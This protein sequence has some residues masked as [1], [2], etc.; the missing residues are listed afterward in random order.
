[1]IYIDPPYNTGND[2]I[3]PDDYSE[4]L[5]TYL[6]YTGQ[7]D[8]D[9]RKFGTNTDAAGRFDSKWLNMMFPRLYLARN[10]LTDDGFLFVSIDDGEVENLKRLCDEVFG[11][12]R[13]VGRF[14]VQTNPKGRVLDRHISRTH[15]Y[16]LVYEKEAASREL[17]IAKSED[18]VSRDYALADDDGRHYRLLEL[19]NTHRQFGRETRP[20]L[21]YPLYVDRTNDKVLVAPSATAEEVWPTWDDGFEG[22][23]TWGRDKA[24]A[25]QGLLKWREVNGRLKIY[26]K[27]YSHDDDGVIVRKKL[28]SILLDRAFAT[29]RGQEALDSIMGERL[30]Q[31]PKP[32][33]LIA[34]FIEMATSAGDT[35]LDFFG[36]SGTSA[37]ATL[38][39]NR[40]SGEERNYIL[41]Q[42]PEPTGRID[43]KTIVDITEE[44][45]RR[46]A[47]ADASSEPTPAQAS[48]IPKNESRDT[49][50]R[51]FRL[52]ESNVKV[53]DTT[54]ARDEA[55]VD[56]QLA[57]SIDHL[58]H[59]RTDLDVLYEVLIKEGFPLSSTVVSETVGDKLV[60]SIADGAFLVCLDRNLDFELVR[61]IAG[62]K[63]ERVLLLDEGFAGNDQ[64]KTNAVQTFKS[65]NIVLKTL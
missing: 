62:R 55:A 50:F 34:A 10:L 22:C 15:D 58:R 7:V 37:H 11:E 56:A 54:V 60:Y 28:K 4:S 53:W 44:R 8:S 2:F 6:E 40:S 57:L 65:K 16:V 30:F 20:R 64:L 42:L 26:R 27:A 33:D 41:V 52:A 39:L 1:M 38:Q 61:A 47:A 24:A 17:G 51:V 5:Q 19:R 49:G 9:G 13:H 14:V 21:W 35:V 12:D 63:P 32:V 3:Y 59:D 36:G 43:Y 48:L 25:D 45:M 18:E 29:E 23:W 31:S 46:F